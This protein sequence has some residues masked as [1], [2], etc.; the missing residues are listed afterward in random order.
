MR[1]RPRIDSYEF[2]RIEIDG[3]AYTSDVII[4]P[5]GV[6]ANWRRAEGHALA[7]SDL[8]VVL[9]AAP[10][11]LVI[12]Q[13][14]Y[15]QMRAPDETLRRLEEAGIEVACVP[16]AQAVEIYNARVACGEHVAAALH[17]TC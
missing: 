15:G 12:G 1:E 14:A 9:K 17:L 2:G 3:R 10:R 13:G 16:T 5:T 7:P 4:L 6:E 8:T 11:V